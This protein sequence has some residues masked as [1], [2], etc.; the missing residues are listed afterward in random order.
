[1]VNAKTKL[2]YVPIIRQQTLYQ[3]LII[4]SGSTWTAKFRQASPF[5]PLFAQSTGQ[6][7]RRSSWRCRSKL[8]CQMN[9]GFSCEKVLFVVQKSFAKKCAKVLKICPPC[10]AKRNFISCC[11]LTPPGNLLLPLDTPINP[12]PR[13]RYGHTWARRGGDGGGIPPCMWSN[14]M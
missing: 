14:L 9:W 3:F 1:M 5:W 6:T 7:R 11:P 4:Y 12:P 8:A 2:K 10:Y 13:T